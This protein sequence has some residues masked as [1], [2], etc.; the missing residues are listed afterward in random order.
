MPSAKRTPSPTLGWL[1]AFLCTAHYC[2]Y[3]RAGL[4]L[5][6]H[7]DSVKK[8]VHKLEGWLSKVLIC[9]IDRPIELAPGDGDDFVEVAW[10]IL[11]AFLD[12]RTPK[13]ALHADYSNIAHADL[14]HFLA[15]ADE[16]GYHGVPGRWHGVRAIEA[17][18]GKRL[19]RGRGTLSLSNEGSE[20][21][22]VAVRIVR[23]LDD[24]RAFLPVDY[25]PTRAGIERVFD[26]NNVFRSRLAAIAAIIERTGKK[27]RGRVRLEDVKRDL[28]T[29]NLIRECM[30]DLVGPLERVSGK[31]IEFPL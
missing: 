12:S 7:A 31:D 8:R 13:A 26:A 22:G 10:G 27:Q 5:G 11:R 3:A 17:A 21:R 24:F 30:I 6:L 9:D 15:A 19:F 28:N 18:L 23:A 1:E 14:Q 4:D 25:D 20:F 16:A 29:G 2:D